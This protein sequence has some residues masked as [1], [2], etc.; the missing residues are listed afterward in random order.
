[1]FNKQSEKKNEYMADRYRKRGY[2]WWWHSFT[3]KSKATGKERAFFIEFF[4]VNPKLSPNQVV[5]GQGQGNTGKKKKRPSYLMIKCGSWGENKKQ[6]HRFFPLSEAEIVKRPFSVRAGDCFLNE[7]ETRGSVCVPEEEANEATMSDSGSMS[8][9]LTID[10]K[11]AFDVGYGTSPFFV[12][13]KAFEMYWHAQG[14]KT[15]YSGVVTYEGEEYEVIPET[16]YGYADKNWGRDFTSPW[17]WL[18]S[19][20]IRRQGS[21]EW[22][23]N[24]A[25]D[26]GGGT[27][28]VFGISIPNQL[29]GAFVVEG[30]EYEMNFSKFWTLTKTDFY[31]R[32]RGEEARWHV[33]LTN[34]EYKIVTDVRCKT[35]EMLSLNY[36]TPMGERKHT[37]LYNGGTGYGTIK[38]YKRGRM[39]F[40]LIDTLECF[41]VGCEY[42]EAEKDENEE[43]ERDRYRYRYY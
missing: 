40:T 3:G 20:K 35:E 25:F 1:M 28:K 19:N 41:S 24:T 11:I 31:F 37:R 10:K 14:I 6:L 21:E 26:I 18:S 39:K 22:L 8:W 16:S 43:E 23:E 2:D 34:R 17:L 29:L 30:K 32:D 4:I 27:P 7:T 9:N 13:L 36:E 12:A 42:G 5:L 33:E 38:F 15:Q